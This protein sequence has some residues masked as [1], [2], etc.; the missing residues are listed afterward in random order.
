MPNLQTKENAEARPPEQVQA[1]KLR[2]D[3]DQEL[4]KLEP[5]PTISRR[6]AIYIPKV[7]LRPYHQAALLAGNLLRGLRV[8]V[9]LCDAEGLVKKFAV[10][11]FLFCGPSQWLSL[12]TGSSSQLFGTPTF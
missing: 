2:A 5:T 11:V 8:Q 1:A 10:S 7:R 4:P 3:S 12:N 6:L 9:E